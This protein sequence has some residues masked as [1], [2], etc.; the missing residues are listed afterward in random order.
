M[1]GG[2]QL[3]AFLGPTRR[4]LV[5]GMYDFGTRHILAA[6]KVVGQQVG[7]T[8]LTL[9]MQKGASVGRGPRWMISMTQRWSRRC[10]RA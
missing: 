9:A 6:L 7:F 1:Q 2:A 10:A 5:V 8:K 3:A 4:Q